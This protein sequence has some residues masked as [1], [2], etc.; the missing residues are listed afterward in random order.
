MKPRLLQWLACPACASVDLKLETRR[1]EVRPV[2]RGHFEEGETDLPGVDL[3][4]GQE[5]IVI[6]G[7]VHCSQALAANLVPVPLWIASPSATTT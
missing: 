4:E 5:R 7:A 6:E 3:T 1:Q 2:A